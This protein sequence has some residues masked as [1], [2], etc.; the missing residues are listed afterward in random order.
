MDNKIEIFKLTINSGNEKFTD[1]QIKFLVECLIK[2]EQLTTVKLPFKKP[3]KNQNGPRNGPI[4]KPKGN[5]PLGHKVGKTPTGLS[6]YLKEKM[7]DLKTNGSSYP[8]NK[9]T[10][11]EE[12]K[13]LSPEDRKTWD[14]KVVFSD[15]DM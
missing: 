14:E 2:T 7:A 11:I 12:W 9:K 13:S 8:E 15:L 5:Q 10:A 1:E 3:H 6:L 4:N